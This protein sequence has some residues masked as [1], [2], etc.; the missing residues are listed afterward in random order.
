MDVKKQVVIIIPTFNEQD[1]IEKTILD[2]ENVI[3]QINSHT[4][5]ILVFDSSSTDN[6]QK[7]VKQLQNEF[8]NIFLMTEPKKSGLGSAYVKAMTYVMNEINPDIIFQFDADGSHQPKYI[9]AMLELLNKEADVVVGSRYVSGGSIPSNW[10][11]HRKLLSRAGNLII[12]LFLTKKYSDYTTGFRGLYVKTLRQISL[13]ALSNNYTFLLN[14]I[15]SLHKAGAKIKEYPIEFI[16]REKGYSKLPLNNITDSL[17]LVIC[18]R[19]LEIKR[20]FFT[21]K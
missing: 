1:S 16:D 10:A 21:S 20:Y 3:L 6:T 15:W 14:Q 11:F 4:I 12:R 8:E 13:N 7:I 2:L 19:F 9:P 18:L 17:K 5:S